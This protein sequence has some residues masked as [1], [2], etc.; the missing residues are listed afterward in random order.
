MRSWIIGSGDDCDLVVARPTVSGRHCRLTET[1]TGYFVEDLGSSNGTYVNGVRITL[2]TRV[3]ASD[4]ITLGQ[5]I[6]HAVAGR[7]GLAG[8]EGHPDRPRSRQ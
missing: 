5:T 2:S 6:L 4:T 3:S 7:P 1:A 8:R